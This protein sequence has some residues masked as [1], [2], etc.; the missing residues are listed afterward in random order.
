MKKIPTSYDHYIVLLFYTGKYAANSCVVDIARTVDHAT[1]AIFYVLFIVLMTFLTIILTVFAMSYFLPISGYLSQIRGVAS[2]RAIGG[3]LRLTTNIF[4][5]GKRNG[6]E[7]WIQSGCE[8]YEKRLKPVMDV[9]TVFLKSDEELIKTSRQLKGAVFALDE[10]GKQ[11]SSLDFTNVLYEKGFIVGGS[12][13]NFLVG[14]FSGL[15]IEIKNKF[16]LLSLSKM[17]WTHQMARLLL[18]EQIYRAAEIRKGS[19][20]HKE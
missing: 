9:T 17:T 3:I 8:E 13:V 19:S 11:Y 15:P 6:G 5:V 18:I 4:I 20:Y 10:T 14:G 16:H 7:E 2:H 1:T 12:Q